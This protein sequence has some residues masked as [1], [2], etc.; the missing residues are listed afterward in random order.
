MTSGLRKIVFFVLLLSV[1]YAAYRFMIKP[2]NANLAQQKKQLDA[3]LAKLEEFERATAKAE[4]L[5]EQ[6]EQLEEAVSFFE[7]K[8]PPK[9]QIYNVLEQVTVIAQEKGLRPKTI[10][11]MKEKNNSGYIEQPLKMELVGNFG[12]FYSFLLELEK[13]PRIMKIRDLKLKGKTKK[14]SEISA[15]FVLSIFFQNK[16]S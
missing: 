3:K 9:S 15:D 7:S 10:R 16:I 4:N 13:L 8:L 12:S 1:T 6:I 14:D 2:A 11:T 5:N